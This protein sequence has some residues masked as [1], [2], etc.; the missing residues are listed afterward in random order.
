MG[1]RG[2]HPYRYCCY[3]TGKRKSFFCCKKIW[4]AS[5]TGTKSV[6]FFFVAVADVTDAKTEVKYKKIGVSPLL[7]GFVCVF[8]SGSSP[9]HTFNAYMNLYLNCVMWKR[10]KETKRGREVQENADV[11]VEA[12]DKSA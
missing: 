3:V 8:H 4:H 9:K 12:L 2:L 11:G 7:S 1:G 5:V 10:R 6:K